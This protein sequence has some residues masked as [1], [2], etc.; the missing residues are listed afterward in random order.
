MPKSQ[1]N[2]RCRCQPGEQA[3]SPVFSLPAA[4]TAAIAQPVHVPPKSDFLSSCSTF[5]PY[6]CLE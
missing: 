1:G 3:A 5:H 4:A 6:T 2:R